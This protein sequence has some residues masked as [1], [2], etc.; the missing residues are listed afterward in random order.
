MNTERSLAL[1]TIVQVGGK[2]C[3][4]LL[5]LVSIGLMTRHLG[6]E[7][8][9]WYTTAISFL[10]FAGILTDFGL[11]PVTSQM[12]SDP[13]FDRTKLLSNLLTFRLVTALLCFTITPFI[14]LLF[15]YPKEVLIAIFLSSIS[16][17]AVALNQIFIGYYQ[18]TLRTHIHALGE[19]L[20]R[21]TLVI[22]LVLLTTY[23]AT[24]L[25]IMALLVLANLVFTLV[26]AV[27]TLKREHLGLTYDSV[28]WKEISTRM[29]PIAISIT[30]NVVY[31]RGDALIL[32]FFRNQSEV[33]LYG[34]A[35][36]VLDIVSQTGMLLMGLLLPL[37]AA[38]WAV[39]D[40]AKFR[41]WYQR[42][43]DLMLMA[44][45]PL[46]VGIALLAKPIIVFVA[47]EAFLP[48]A[49]PLIILSIAIFG[50][51]LGAVFGH[52]AVA[53]GKQKQTIWIYLTNAI[54]T[55]VGYL[56][57]IPI[58]GMNGA[59][60]LSAWSEVYAGVLLFIVVSRYTGIKLTY[61]TPLKAVLAATAM[62]GTIWL[63]LP[64]LPWPVVGMLGVAMYSL[65]LV[66]TRAIPIEFIRDL[67]QKRS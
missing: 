25:P 16:F 29:W 56:I 52:T 53:I 35:Y 60:G 66:I 46:L 43:F 57:F 31:L 21:V 20:G 1:N 63:L 15:P 41:L 2:I 36:R 10:Q 32:P 19:L 4:T 14:A 62:A 33:G 65:F 22:G 27:D 51:Y 13:R 59:A 40:Q 28:L 26:M 34:A 30:C 12:L 48:A 42:S 3:S 44:G 61:A 11:I 38:A 24:F 39:R 17:V 47:G 7:Q 8:F 49:T 58:Y 18:T 37:L 50:V 23:G 9:G 55:L 64:L 67:L 5:G 54:I 6:T 45:L